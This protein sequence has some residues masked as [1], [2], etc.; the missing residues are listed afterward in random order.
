MERVLAIV[1]GLLAVSL[2]LAVLFGPLVVVVWFLASSWTSL[3]IFV[4]LVFLGI[5]LLAYQLSKWH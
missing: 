2:V 4:A 5:L 1:G 3:D